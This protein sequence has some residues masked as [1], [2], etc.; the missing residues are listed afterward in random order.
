VFRDRDGSLGVG[1]NS[2]VVIQDGVNDSVAVDPEACEI[3][4]T[5]N[6]AVCRGDVGRMSFVNGRGLGFGT[7]AAGAVDATL[8]PVILSRKGK[9]FSIHVGTNVRAGT[10][11]KASTERKSMDLNVIE[12]EAGSWVILEIPGFTQAATGAQQDSLDALRKATVTSYYKA[13]DALWVKL[14]SAG[15]HGRGGHGGGESLQVSR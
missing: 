1:P 15:D 3:K 4:P 5:W 10:E 7:I 9:E 2:F 11:I 12:L 13:G 6:A 8:P 14:V